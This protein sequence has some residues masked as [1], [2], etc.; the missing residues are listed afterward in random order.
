VVCFLQVSPPNP[1]ISLSYPP[2]V[3]HAPLTSFFSILSPEQYWVS[4]D[5]EYLHYVS[6]RL[7][8]V[9]FQKTL[10]IINSLQHQSHIF[11]QQ[12]SVRRSI[13]GTAVTEMRDVAAVTVSHNLLLNKFC[14]GS[15][16]NKYETDHG[17]SLQS[18][19]KSLFRRVSKIAKNDY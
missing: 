3:L 1:C 18:K 9:I 13:R 12:V 8:G 19:L 14:G 5:H 2:Y 17:I 6:N 10:I 16:R 15:F 7:H 11:Y 4:T